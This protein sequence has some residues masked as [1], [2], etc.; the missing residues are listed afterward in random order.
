MSSGVTYHTPGSFIKNLQKNG[1]KQR[2]AP[3]SDEDL[4][5]HY[6]DLT[7]LKLDVRRFTPFVVSKRLS[8]RGSVTI[9]HL[10]EVLPHV[11]VVAKKEGMVVL[12]LGGKLAQGRAQIAN[13]IGQSK[14][15]I[16]DKSD[17]DKILA[18]NDQEARAKHLAL[19]LVRFI[20]RDQLSPY[21]TG[22]PAAGGRFFARAANV[23]EILRSAG[24]FTIVGN[25]RIGKTSLLNEVREQ[26]KL[27]NENYQIAEVYGGT[28]H[29]TQDVV[30]EIL[31]KL[32]QTLHA[33]RV[34]E[35]PY[36]VRNL[37]EH[38]HR[39]INS[40]KKPVAVFIDELDHILAFDEKQ[41]DELLHLLRATFL[42]QGSCRIIMAGFRKVMEAAQRLTHPLFNF[43]KIIELPLFSREETYEMV[44]KP[45]SHLDID[46]AKSDLHET[47]FRE[48]NGHPELIQVHCAEIVRHVGEAGEVP[49]ETTHLTRVFELP[50]YKQ[51][52]LGAFLANTNAHEELL[53][54]LLIADGDN[55][56]SAADYEFG[57]MQANSVLREK[58]INYDVSRIKNLT[59]NLRLSGII[60]P[61]RGTGRFRFSVPQFVAYCL[62]LD[63][64]FCIE[65]ALE[66]IK[67]SPDETGAVAHA[68]K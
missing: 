14:I 4:E 15:A 27:Q 23:K 66:K 62:S 17:I 42:S 48:T 31:H 61:V 2:R 36:T 7:S 64:N 67:E 19:A 24:S 52:V 9:E 58:G 47:I 59:D 35:F 34:I 28:C 16:L 60:T 54:Y 1:F 56:G 3:I 65:K 57:L 41:N 10:E 32:G 5:I 63:L 21:V 38:I 8:S 46:L 12:V 22:R 26:L 37:P 45:L 29:S 40:E 39:I 11:E 43:G 6:A 18:Q 13:E 49:D 55:T 44:R 51:K 25:R 50:E 20:G 30:Y 33:N 68:S 53:C